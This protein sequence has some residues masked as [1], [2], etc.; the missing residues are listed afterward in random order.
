MSLSG[1]FG[2]K[3]SDIHKQHIP[4]SQAVLDS[5]QP[6]NSMSSLASNIIPNSLISVEMNESYS[7]LPNHDASNQ[8]TY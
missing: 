5:S 7:N 6:F 3:S 8:V 1:Y 4:A 2:D